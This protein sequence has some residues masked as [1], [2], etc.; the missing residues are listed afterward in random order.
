MRIIFLGRLA[1]QF[2]HERQLDLTPEQT[3]TDAI[4]AL[5]DDEAHILTTPGVSYV[6]DHQMVASDMALGDAKELAFLPPVSGG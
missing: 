6:L 1:D 5:S 2:G 3:V 4:S